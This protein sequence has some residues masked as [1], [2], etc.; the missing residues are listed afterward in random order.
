MVMS[1]GVGELSTENQVV[2]QIQ[3]DGQGLIKQMSKLQNIMLKRIDQIDTNTRYLLKFQFDSITKVSKKL[4][5]V[6]KML[7]EELK[8]KPE[9]MKTYDIQSQVII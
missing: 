1:P 4:K 3:D 7:M 6:D 8:R 2:E 5:N 9:E